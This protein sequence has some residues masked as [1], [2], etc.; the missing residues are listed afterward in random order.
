[1]KNHLILFLFL[2]FSISQDYQ[3][4]NEGP[5]GINYFDIAGTFN[6]PG[7]ND[8]DIMGDVS[9]DEIVN[10]LDIIQMVGYILETNNFSQDQILLGDLNSDSVVDILD[11]IGLVNMILEGTS[12]NPGWSF[13]DEW[14]GY[15]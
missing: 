4:W 14:N 15:E 5:Y 10:I 8:S 1:M 7:L 13:E 11:I 9:Q 12:G 6:L 3:S 2:T